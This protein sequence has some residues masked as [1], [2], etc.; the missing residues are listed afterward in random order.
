[1]PTILC[2]LTPPSAFCSA[3][4]ALNPAGAWLN[5]EEPSPVSDVIMAIVIGEP[6]APRSPSRVLATP[7][8]TLAISVA[9]A[10]MRQDGQSQPAQC[11]RDGIRMSVCPSPKMPPGRCAQGYA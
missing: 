8:A 10:Q 5:S 7:P 9:S 2:P 3:M 1:M 11:I 6:E 4:R